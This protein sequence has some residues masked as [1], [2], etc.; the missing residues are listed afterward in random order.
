[1]IIKRTEGMRFSKTLINE[2]Q[3]LAARV[4]ILRK[5]VDQTTTSNARTT[6]QNQRMAKEETSKREWMNN[7]KKTKEI[8]A[9]AVRQDQ[10]MRH[11]GAVTSYCQSTKCKRP[12]AIGRRETDASQPFK[13][14]KR[15]TKMNSI[16]KEMRTCE[17]GDEKTRKHATETV[18][19]TTHT[20]THRE[21]R[22][23]A[24]GTI[25]RRQSIGTD[26]ETTIPVFAGGEDRR[27]AL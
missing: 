19:E 12:V 26:L 15:A 18:P 1:M 23:A 21:I 16:V 2:R 10:S 3:K 25:N 24:K 7:E 14:N 6:C 27:A 4:I 17:E 8:H 13:E 5:S 20:S 9:G 22:E 11:E